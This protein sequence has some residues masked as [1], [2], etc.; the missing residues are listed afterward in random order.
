MKHLKTFENFSKDTY[1]DLEKVD[2]IFGFGKKGSAY[3]RTIDF[4][5]GDSDEAKEVIELYNKFLKGKKESELRGNPQALKVMKAI[6]KIG[7]KYAKE[8]KLD[9]QDYTYK[10]I[11]TVLEKDFDRKFKG[12]TNT[13]TGE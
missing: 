10:Q 9:S 7:M 8:N 13:D 2:E 1:T 12:G 4:V 3:Q 6:T 11:R 5:E